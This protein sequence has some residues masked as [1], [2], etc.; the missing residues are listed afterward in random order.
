MGSSIANGLQYM[1][2]TEVPGAY[3]HAITHLSQSYNHAL[4]TGYAKKDLTSWRDILD[5]N[6][7]SLE[8]LNAFASTISNLTGRNITN[9]FTKSFLQGVGEWLVKSKTVL[10]A[11]GDK[12]ALQFMKRIDPEWNPS[13]EYVEEDINK[14]ASTFA[15][16][17]HGAHDPRTLPGWMLKDTAIQPFF[18]LASWN[19]AQTNQWMRHVW[20]PA[21]KGNFTPLIMSTLGAIAGGYVI[22]QARE[23][24]ADKKS[25]IPSLSN[26]INSSRGIEGNIPNIAYNLMAMGSYVGFAG[27]L[28]VAGKAVEDMAHKNI[29]QG[30][31]F[32]LD[33]VISGPVT[34]ISQFVSAMLNDEHFDYL[35]GGMKLATD[36]AKE[37][38]QT[39]RIATSWLAN[40]SLAS[41]GEQY[42]KG[43][44]K[45][46]SELRK[47]KM[48]E[49]LPYESQTGI[50]GNPYVDM[51][52]KKFK[53]TGDLGEAMKE[54]PSLISEAFEKSKGN[55]EVLRSELQK[56]KGNS[57]QTFPSFENTPMAFMRYL[58]YLN[59]EM[60]P[61]K[62]NEVL[63]DYIKKNTVNKVKSEMVPTL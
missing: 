48:V 60:G 45:K 16:L 26:I 29:P 33:E 56:L 13:K 19:I 31:T 5:T 27:I 1:N 38:I 49:G 32:P 2:P 4:E 22:K 25:P 30:A 58:T 3:L 50:V 62:A 37:N 43:L 35:Q 21:T 55:P 61:Q 42:S 47:F 51:G 41:E 12:T 9:V 24:L 11:S 52:E 20:T 46:T 36:I 40:T 6:S 34:R 17:I 18:S 57:Y 63:Q 39:A 10:A 53:R 54:L 8:K 7:T 15:S 59:K 44:N 28:S 14:A 23:T